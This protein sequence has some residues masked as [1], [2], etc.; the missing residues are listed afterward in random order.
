[1][2][3]D[4]GSKKS[5]TY[6]VFAD[7]SNEVHKL[8]LAQGVFSGLLIFDGILHEFRTGLRRKVLVLLFGADKALLHLFGDGCHDGQLMALQRIVSDR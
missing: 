1:M 6:V 4:R 7:R 8:L 5:S 2:C 3:N